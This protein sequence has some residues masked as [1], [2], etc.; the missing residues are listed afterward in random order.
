[1]RSLS[2][3]LGAAVD[4]QRRRQ[5]SG[6]GGGGPSASGAG[7]G[8]NA[9]TLLGLS[10]EAARDSRHAPATLGAPWREMAA[11]AQESLRWIPCCELEQ[12]EA[13]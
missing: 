12:R 8:A 10:L 2:S 1:M 4:A 11:H 9:A 5:G 13:S 3:A 7:A 6:A